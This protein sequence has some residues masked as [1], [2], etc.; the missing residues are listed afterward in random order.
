MC[1]YT[2]AGVR[3]SS[4]RPVLRLVLGQD[5]LGA[6][7]LFPQVGHLLPQSRVLLLQEAGSDGDLVLLQ[8]P[9]VPGPLGC[10]VVLPAPGPVFVILL[11]GRHQRRGE[12]WEK[13]PQR[14]TKKDAKLINQLLLRCARFRILGYLSDTSYFN[15]SN[16]LT[17]TEGPI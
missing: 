5:V 17:Q 4:Q 2:C 15:T 14:K 12:K 9:G 7:E 1:V 10:H 8:S 16:R 3:V 6:S 11:K 13:K